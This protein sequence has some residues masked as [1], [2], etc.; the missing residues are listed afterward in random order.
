MNTTGLEACS[1]YDMAICCMVKTIYDKERMFDNLALL[2]AWTIQGNPAQA[3]F[4][5]GVQSACVLDGI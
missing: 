3:R 2:S 5:R 1:S 4:R